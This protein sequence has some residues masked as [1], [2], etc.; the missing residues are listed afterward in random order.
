MVRQAS[1]VPQG[2]HHPFRR[3]LVPVGEQPE[4]VAALSTQ[5]GDARRA[6]GMTQQQLADAV[7]VDRKT[8]NRWENGRTHGLGAN[9]AKLAQ[10]LGWP[11]EQALKMVQGEPLVVRDELELALHTQQ[12]IQVNFGAGLPDDAHPVAVELAGLLADP[13]VSA[14]T[15][16]QLLATLEGVMAAARREANGLPARDVVASGPA[17]VQ[18]VVEAK[19]FHGGV[20]L[21]RSFI[22]AILNDETI[23]SGDMK[24][25]K[26]L[27]GAFV[28]LG[29]TASEAAALQRQLE[30]DDDASS[31][32][33]RAV[34][35][36]R[37]APRRA[38]VADPR[39]AEGKTRGSVR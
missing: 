33:R 35:S 5:I 34:E 14:G 36:L 7:G 21:D 11:P 8:V 38:A 9:Y 22:D 28:T 16:T 23:R 29:Q 6:K 19:S 2:V 37:E 27:L 39:E 4:S 32:I 20:G 15:R 17:G 31:T 1:R 3:Y 26:M 18:V 12:S 25:L 24:A 13:R 10:A 30:A